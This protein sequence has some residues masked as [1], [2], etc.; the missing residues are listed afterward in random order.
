VRQGDILMTRGGPNSRVGVVVYVYDT[1]P[2]LMMSD[3]LYRIVPNATFD[4]EYLVLALSSANTQMHLSRLK[5]GLAES[6][7]NISQAIVRRLRVARPT[8]DEQK[9]IA[10]RIRSIS[11]LIACEEN[12]LAKRKEHKSGLMQDLLTGK[13]RVKVEETEEVAAHA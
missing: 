12:T 3:K 4:P 7:T 13:V 11:K 6:Q 5:T 8:P 10:K 9:E 1:Q 2:M